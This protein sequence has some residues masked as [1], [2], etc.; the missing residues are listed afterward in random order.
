MAQIQISNPGN[1]ANE[2]EKP[3]RQ[4]RK[5]ASIAAETRRAA[6]PAASMV[7]AADHERTSTA[8]RKGGQH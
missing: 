5:V 8:G 3:R 4:G 6:I 1:F 7:V 2:R